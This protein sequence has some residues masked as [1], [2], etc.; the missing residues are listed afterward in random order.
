MPVRLPSGLLPEVH[1]NRQ[2][3]DQQAGV[4]SR[5]SSFKVF[6]WAGK[7]FTMRVSSA[8]V[9]VPFW[10]AIREQWQSVG[11]VTPCSFEPA[12]CP[13]VPGGSHRRRPSGRIF[14]LWFCLSGAACCVFHLATSTC[15]S[16]TGT[17]V[18]GGRNPEKI[19]GQLN[20]GENSR[21]DFL[22]VK[23]DTEKLRCGI[24]S[25]SDSS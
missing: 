16:A 8:I 13:L 24:I 6:G 2:T 21:G 1:R 17:Q 7:V 18:R 5:R 10:H 22:R 23:S 12:L 25:G 11:V 14:E 20:P 4:P 3:S 9:P 15:G 19:G